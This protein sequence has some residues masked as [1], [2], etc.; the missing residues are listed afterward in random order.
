MTC[1]FE[2][3]LAVMDR[4]IQRVQDNIKELE[5]ELTDCKKMAKEMRK[6]VKEIKK[7]RGKNK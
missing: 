2:T 1:S 6:T 7:E 3:L 4:K 5:S